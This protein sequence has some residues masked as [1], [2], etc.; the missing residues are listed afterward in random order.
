MVTEYKRFRGKG[1]HDKTLLERVLLLNE[2]NQFCDMVYAL[3]K[4]HNYDKEHSTLSLVRYRSVYKKDLIYFRK[5]YG[6]DT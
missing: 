2:L 1:C 3:S 6:V 4:V 5:R